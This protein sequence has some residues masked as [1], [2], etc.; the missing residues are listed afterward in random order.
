MRLNKFLAEAGIASR[1]GSDEIIRAGRVTVNGHKPQEMG[2]QVD[3]E[4]DEV[5]IDGR[6]VTLRPHSVYCMLN[7]PVG[8]LTTVTDPHGRKTVM[9]LLKGIPERI[10]PVGRLDFDTDGLLLITNDGSLS[11][12]L[13]HPRYQIEKEYKVEVNGNPTPDQLRILESGILLDGRLT[14]QAKINIDSATRRKTSLLVTV[15]EGRK[16]Q[17]RFMF[18]HIGF[19]VNGLTRLRIGPVHLGSLKD[20]CWRDLKEAEVKELRSAAGTN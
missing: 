11:N 1:R 15:K 9:E 2:V 13:T 3:P 12:A 5:K 16:R 4:S 7:K 20:S 19:E 17:I 14:G 10:Y 8:Y 18:R 6:M